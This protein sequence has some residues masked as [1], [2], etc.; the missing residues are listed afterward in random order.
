MSVIEVRGLEKRFGSVTA[1]RDL[2]FEVQ[3]GSV[4][5]FLGPNGAGKTN[6]GK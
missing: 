6:L 2:S 5:G 4:T 1:V 3:A